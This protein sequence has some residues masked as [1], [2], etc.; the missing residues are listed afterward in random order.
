LLE[1]LS[2]AG[3]IAMAEDSDASFKEP[4]LLAIA[5]RE[6]ILEKPDDGLGRGEAGC[7]GAMF[8]TVS[9]STVKPRRRR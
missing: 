5:L 2:D 8:L 6:L 1:R 4:V 3:K 7:H 9:I